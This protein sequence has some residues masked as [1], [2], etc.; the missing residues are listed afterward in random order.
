MDVNA[1]YGGANAAAVQNR[2]VQPSGSV[3]VTERPAI[4]QAE[5]PAVAQMQPNA[6]PNNRPQDANA[7]RAPL[8][9]ENVTDTM[10][11]SAFEDA[12]NVL[13]GSSFRLSYAKHEDTGRIMVTVYERQS[14]EVLR[15]IPS[16]SRLDIYA[17]ITEFVGLL[18]DQGN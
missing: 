17:R 2:P 14:D 13:S 8:R 5:R 18:F 1:N 3:T 16:E 9:E 10:L 15:E 4:R 12:N 6:A 7:S 11:D